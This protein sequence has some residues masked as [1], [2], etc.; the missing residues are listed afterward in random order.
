MHL[1]DSQRVAAQLMWHDEVGSTNDVLRELVASSPDQVVDRMV[2]ATSSQ[3]SGRGRLGR[4][5][6]APPGKALAFSVLVQDFSGMSPGWLPLIAGTAVRR[7]IG[8]FV[9]ESA[10]GVKWPNDVQIAEHKVSGILSEMLPDGSIIVGIGVN[11]ALAEHELPTERATSLAMHL[12][13]TTSASQAL[14]NAHAETDSE[15]TTETDLETETGTETQ[16]LMDAVL[17]SILRELYVLLDTAS[18]GAPGAA[19]QVRSMVADDSATLG[20]QV[21]AL[22]PSGEQV[23]GVA[24]RLAADGALVIRVTDGREVVVAAGDIEHLR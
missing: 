3:T 11:V 13:V 7:G 1:P 24:V 18:S 14:G 5:W 21:V 19:E 6:I 12:D 22:L 2:V 17:A 10:V 20:T 4:E 15:T 9:P 8:A 23:R 16:A